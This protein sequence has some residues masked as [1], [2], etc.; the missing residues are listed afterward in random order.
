[1]EVDLR[2]VLLRLPIKVFFLSPAKAVRDIKKQQGLKLF[3]S[4]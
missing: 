3:F 2:K 1:L 4:Y